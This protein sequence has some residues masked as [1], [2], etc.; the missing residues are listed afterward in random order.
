MFTFLKCKNNSS[1]FANVRTFLLEKRREDGMN[2]Y[3]LKEMK[4]RA[5]LKEKNPNS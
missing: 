3:Q 1:F 2:E 4:A 5:S